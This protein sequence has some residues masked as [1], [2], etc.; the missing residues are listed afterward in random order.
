VCRLTSAKER[1]WEVGYWSGAQN[2]LSTS[3][4]AERLAAKRL[5]AATKRTN[6]GRPAR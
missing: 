6:N 4:I 3:G 1:R 5:A 2:Y